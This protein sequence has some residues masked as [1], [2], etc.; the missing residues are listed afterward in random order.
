MLVIL[1]IYFACVIAGA[2]YAQ[3]LVKNFNK[4]LKNTNV[5][6]ACLIKVRCIL[7]LSL[8]FPLGTLFCFSK[9]LLAS[10]VVIILI[11]LMI[12][13]IYRTANQINK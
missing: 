11:N 8:T 4:D 5:A 12:L 13:P 2:V 3:N 10:G 7:I 1:G 9:N 6:R